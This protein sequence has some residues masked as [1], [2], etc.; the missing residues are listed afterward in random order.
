MK[1]AGNHNCV[2]PSPTLTASPEDT[3]SA[4]VDAELTD[5]SGRLLAKAR[6]ELRIIPHHTEKTLTHGDVL[7]RVEIEVAAI[8]ARSQDR[9]ALEGARRHE[10]GWQR[11]RAKR[12]ASNE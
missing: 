8:L 12:V 10:E 11:W 6:A 7:K 4:E 1:R 9:M 3:R 5:E 2:A